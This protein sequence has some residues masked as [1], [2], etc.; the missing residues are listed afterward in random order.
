MKRSVM[1]LAGPE[2]W[3]HPGRVPIPHLLGSGDPLPPLPIDP[4]IGEY[5][6]PGSRPSL[7][8]R[9]SAANTGNQTTPMISM[10][11]T[12]ALAAVLAEPYGEDGFR[13]LREVNILGG[14]SLNKEEHHSIRF[15]DC[16][17][18]GTG[19]Y[20]IKSFHAVGG[21]APAGYYPEFV[22]CTISGGTSATIIGGQSRFIRSRIEKGP[23]LFKVFG[24]L[25]V[26]A[27]LVRWTWHSPGAH[28]DVFQLTNGG[29][30]STIQWSSLEG[31]NHPN[32]P[33]GN[34]GSPCNAVLQT[35]T[36]TGDVGPVEWVNNWMDG[37]HYTLRGRKPEDSLYSADYLFR[38]N[39]LGRNTTYGPLQ[40]SGYPGFD[41][42]S[43]NVWDDTN[44]PVTI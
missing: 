32:S 27:C 16:N 43:S 20:T 2:E 9:P 10:S 28:A 34:G 12:E 1:W 29:A 6:T 17:I 37:G 4:P 39:R 26:Y 31:F 5:G 19:S 18:E 41:F 13:T 40:N 33:S 3:L 35:G 8:T 11:G 14:L 38:G 22:R 42:D 7:P 21:V 23:D 25:E 15:V 36:Q 30:N 44:L 24:P